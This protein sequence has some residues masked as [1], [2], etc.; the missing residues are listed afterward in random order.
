MVKKIFYIVSVLLLLAI[1]LWTY[2]IEV[3]VWTIPK[4]VKIT[5]PV[6]EYKQ[7]IWPEGPSNPDTSI[8][9]RKPNIILILADDLGFN[10]VSFYNGGAGDGTLMTPNIDRIGKEGVAFNN[11]YAASA[12]C[13]PSRASLMTGRYSTRFGYEFTPFYKV[14]QTIFRWIDEIENP[15]LKNQFTQIDNENFV[16]DDEYGGMPSSEITIAEVLKQHGYYNAH[17]GKWHLGGVKGQLP[18]DQGFDDSLQLLSPLYLPKEDPSIVNAYTDSGIDRMIWA[19]SQFSV[20]FNGGEAFE[21]GGYITDYYTDEALKV[22]EKNKNQP[23]FLYLGHFAPHNPLQALKKDFEHFH[24]LTDKSD[25]QLRVYSAM[26]RSL[27]RSVG[28]ILDSLEKNEI[29]ENTLIIFSSDN[30]GANYIHLSD[31]NKPYR[32]WKLT[33]FEGGMHIPFMARW[34]AEIKSGIIFDHP[35]HQN[36]I[37][38]TFAAAAGA[39]IPNDR[40]IDGKNILPFIKENKAPHNTLFWRQ[41]RLQTILH[42]QWKMIFD[43]NQKKTWLFNL[44]TDPTERKNLTDQMPDKIK[45]LQGLLEEHNSQQLEPNFLSVVATPILIDKHDGEEYEDSDEYTFWDN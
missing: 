28:K 19:A 34:P 4:I 5:Q 24:H 37:F 35:V 29:S 20:R 10:D 17:I 11:G 27:D 12:S 16:D 26:I 9:N 33:H 38:S 21:P 43:K 23:F 39:T 2:R 31:I 41:G 14:G 32:G 30:G 15:K 6:A 3:V 7:V 36:D 25:H 42:H 18:T 22:I 44:K 8:E 40:I 45:L 1:I 13:S